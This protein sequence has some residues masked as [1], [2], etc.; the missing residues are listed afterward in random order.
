MSGDTVDQLYNGLHADGAVTGTRENF[1]KFF[2]APGKQGY[3]NRLQLY[4]ALHAD[5]AVSSGTYE[6][7]AQKLGLH[8]RSRSKAV[9]QAVA[10]KTQVPNNFGGL[11]TQTAGMSWLQ[12][13]NMT[14]KQAAASEKRKAASRAAVKGN[15]VGA[16]E[17]VTG[18]KAVAPHVVKHDQNKFFTQT[19]LGDS[20][21]ALDYGDSIEGRI[22]KMEDD[23][24]NAAALLNSQLTKEG[25]D[26]IDKAFAEMAGKDIQDNM[27]MTTDP[28]DAMGN[29]F[30]AM[31]GANQRYGTDAVIKAYEEALPT[32]F[33][34]DKSRKAISEQARKLGMDEEE[35]TQKYML[36]NIEKTIHD[37]LV[38]EG[39]PKSDA[40]YFARGVLS[41]IAGNIFTRGVMTRQGR[42]I[43][44]E[45]TEKYLSDL[46]TRI[47]KD[48]VFSKAGLAKYGNIGMGMASDIAAFAGAGKIAGGM[49]SGLGTGVNLLTKTPLG[50]RLLGWAATSASELT[51]KYG[52]EGAARIAN[53]ASNNKTWLGSLLTDGA[54]GTLRSGL[55]L[56]NYGAMQYATGEGYDKIED[57]KTDNWLGGLL[58]SYSDEFK[59]GLK[60][61]VVGAV[62]STVGRNVGITGA[63]ASNL[64]KITNG[65]KKAAVT[66][67]AFVAESLAFRSEQMA[68]EWAKDHN[69][70]FTDNFIQGAC[71]NMAMKLGGGHYK[72]FSPKNIL[73]SMTMATG[74]R[75]LKLTDTEKKIFLENTDARNLVAA[76]DALEPNHKTQGEGYTA[77]D[78]SGMKYEDR[79]K[80]MEKKKVD[81]SERDAQGNAVGKLQQFLDNKEIPLKLR[82]K[83]SAALGGTMGRSIPRAS[84][85][86]VEQGEKGKYMVKEYSESGELIDAKEH[87]TYDS[88]EGDRQD[89]Y[90]KRQDRDFKDEYLNAMD[91]TTQEDKMN[92]MELVAKDNGFES[93]EDMIHESA[94]RNSQGDDSLDKKIKAD[95][96]RRREEYAGTKAKK[97]LD[98]QR[99]VS[100]EYGVD[101][102]K[103]MDKDFQLRTDQENE[104]IEEFKKRLR[105]E[106][107]DK[108]DEAQNNAVA[109]QDGADLSEQTELEDS[110]RFTENAKT[111]N[112]RQASATDA[113][114]E[115]VK[116]NPDLEEWMK[117]NPN[118]SVEEL[119]ENFGD[120]VADAYMELSNAQAMRDG[121]MQNTGSKIED[122]VRNQVEQAKFTGTMRDKQGGK[123]ITDDVVTIFADKD[124]NEYTLVG[125]DVIAD[126]AGDGSYSAGES[127]LVI[128][129]DKDGNLVQRTN[130]DGLNKVGV[131]PLEDYAN[132]IRT[133]LQEQKTAEMQS[134]ETPLPEAPKEEAPKRE[135][136]ATVAA[137]EK[138]EPNEAN[139]TVLDNPEFYKVANSLQNK[140]GQSLSMDE[141]NSLVSEMEGRAEP[142]RELELTPENWTA[143]FG[144]DGKVNTPVGKV[145]MGENQ[146]AKLFMKG[147]DAEFGMIKPT[148]TSPDVIIEEESKAADGNEE[149]KSSYL[150]V[151]TFIRDGEKVKFFTS[152][153]VKK[154]GMEVSVSSHI[155]SKNAIDKKMQEGKILYIKGV[156]TSNSSDR[157]LA[158]HPNG[159]PDLLPTQEDDT[160]STGKDTTKSSDLQAGNETL[161]F[162]DGTEAP[163]NYDLND[164]P[165][166]DNGEPIYE[167]VSKERTVQDLFGKLDDG[168]LAREY[169]EMRISEA[170]KE[171]KEAKKKE[172][173]MG[174]KINEYLSKK[175]EYE[176]RVK[177]AEDKVA[178]WESVKEDI[179]KLTHTTPEE[180]KEAKEELDG[181]AAREE[182]KK[183]FDE[184]Q[185]ADGVA[186]AAKFVADAKV[187]PESFKKETGMGAA[188]QKS[189]VGMIAKE[190]KGGKSIERLGEDL[191]QLD[192]DEYGGVYFHGDSNDARSAIISALTGAKT[193]KGLREMAEP[194]MERTVSERAQMRDE[195]YNERYGMD[196]EEYLLYS[197][198]EMPHI[199]GNLN[200]FDEQKY[201]QDKAV[202]I[203][204]Q[205]DKEYGKVT[206]ENDSRGEESVHVEG[207]KVLSEERPNDG[208]G[209]E[210]PEKHGG[211]EK[212][213]R[214]SN[215]P[216]APLHE[217]A[218][219]GEGVKK[220]YRKGEKLSDPSD[221]A[222]GIRGAAE[223]FHQERVEKA[224]KAYEEA[225]ASGDTSETKRTKDEY[226]K[227]LDDQLKAQGIGL[228]ERRKTIA[229]EMGEGTKTEEPKE[230]GPKEGKKHWD[231]LSPTEKVEKADADPLTEEEIRSDEENKELA[232]AAIAYLNGD[233][234]LLN[235]IAYLKIYGNV[236]S[237][238]EDVPGNSGT[239]DKA[240]LA[241]S[242]NGSGEG[243]ELEPGRSGGGS[244]EPLDSGTG[245]EAA[246]GK[247]KSGTDSEG[248]LDTAAGEGGDIKGEGNTPGL[249]GV[250]A[251][252]GGR[253]RGGA[254]GGNGNLGSGRGRGSSNGPSKPDGKRKPAA[255]QG[256]TFPN[257]KGTDVK[258][259]TSDAKAAMKAA[260]AEF[261]KRGKKGSASIS[262]VGM[263]NEQIEYL[264]ELMKATGRYGI[265]VMREG[266]YK[267]KEWFDNIREAISDDMKDIGFKDA[268]IDEYI[269]EMWH[270]PWEMDGETHKIGEWASIKG[271]A[272]LRESLKEPLRKKFDK[273]VL[274]EAT[275]VKVGDRKNIEE[276][277]PFLLPQ[278]QD[279]VLKAETQF[280]DES[281]KDK[282]HAGGKGYM[283]TNG[284]GTGKTYTGLGI[285]KRMTKQ[286]KGRILIVTPS[287][288][289]VKDWIN[290]GKNLCLDIRDLDD[291]SKEHGS[292]ATNEKGEGVV[293]TTFANF[294]TNK[295][296][297]EDQFDAVI[298]DESHRIMENKDANETARSRQHYMLTNRNERYALMRLEEINPD[299]MKMRGLAE[300]FEDARKKETARIKEEYEK[301]N[302]SADAADVRI[303]MV[304][305]T[306]KDIQSFSMA[307][308]AK[309]PELGKIYEDYRNAR[310]YYINNV[311]PELEK[312]AKESVDKTKVVFLSA[313]PFNTRE[314]IEYAEGYL[315]SYPERN[316]SG[317]S[318]KAQFFL[319]HFGA[320]YKFRYNRLESST[321]NAE[322][323]AKQEVAFSDW[324]Q[325]DLGTMSGRI[326]DSPYDYSRDFPTVS[327]EHAREFNEACEEISRDDVFGAAYREVLGDY[328]YGSALFET[329]KVAAMLPRLREHIAAGR[330]VVVFHRRVSSKEPLQAPFGMI[331]GENAEKAIKKLPKDKQPEARVRLN[332][333][334]SKY[335]ELLKWEQ[336]L[337]F[338][339]PREQLAKAFGEDN[340]LYFSGQESSKVKNEA[341]KQFND[342]NSGK[343]IIV[344]QEASGK[345]G[346][347][348]HDTTG[349]HQRV[350]I[351]LALPQSPITALQIEG[352]TYRIGNESNAIFEYPVL[353]LV[354]EYNLFAS[355][356]NQQVSTT[357]NLAL[358]SQA[359]NLRE[360]FARGI[361]EHSG[362]VPLDQQGVGGK[363][364]DKAD[365]SGSDPY[366]N[367]V[368][369]YYTNQKLNRNNREGV[370][371]F[372]TP[373]PLGY[374]VVEWANIGEGDSVLEPSAGHGAIARYVPQTNEL[375]AIEPSMSLFA[376]LQMKAG[377]LGR[378]FQNGTFENYYI[379]NKHDA[380]VMNPPFGKAGATAIAHLEKAFGHLEEGGRMVAIIPRGAMDAK[381]VKWAESNKSV[382]PRAYISLPDVTF[383]QAG[384]KVNCR[385]VVI[386]KITDAKL[387]EKADITHV[388]LNRHYDKIEDFF[389]DLRGVEVP[390]RII[391]QQA[392]QMKKSKAAVSELRNMRG[393][394]DVSLDRDG[395]EVGARG[396]RARIEF[397]ENESADAF[398]KRMAGLYDQFAQ[399]EK[400]CANYNMDASAVY[401][402]LK[403]LTC[404]LADMTEDEM[405]RYLT[406]KNSNSYDE[407]GVRFRKG[408]GTG[409]YAKESRIVPQDV[410]KEVSSQIERKF[411][412]DIEKAF[413]DEKERG[414]AESVIYD[415]VEHYSYMKTSEIIDNVNE[416]KENYG[417]ERR[418]GGESSSR[419]H[420]TAVR[421][422]AAMLAS[423]REMEYRRIRTNRIKSLFGIEGSERQIPI[424]GISK[425]FEETK[426]RDSRGRE[427]LFRASLDIA[428]R[429]GTKFYLEE[430]GPKAFHIGVTD[431]NREI[432]FFLD[433]LTRTATKAEEFNVAIVHELLHQSVNGAINLVKKGKAEGFL[434]EKQ[435]DGA[436]TILDIYNKVKGDKERFKE[437]TYGLKS[438]YEFAAQMADQRQRQALDTDIFERVVSA[439]RELVK[440]GDYSLWQR[441]KD[442][443]GKLIGTSDLKKMDKALDNI[444][445]DFKEVVHDYS[446]E[447]IE[448]E[449]FG[450][451]VEDPKEIERLEKEP[452]VKVY[453][454]MQVIDGKLYPPMAAKVRGGLVEPRELGEWERADENPDLAIPDIDKKTGK[455]KVDK[456][457][458]ELKWK[459]KLDK[460]G[461]DAKGKKLGDV[462]AAYN[463]YWHTS[464]SPLNDQFSSA[465]KRPNLRVVEVE[466]PESEL[467]SGYKAERAKDAVGEM[468][469]HSG[470]VSSKLPKEKE[471]KVILSRWDKPVRVLSDAEAADKIAEMLKGEDIEIPDNTITPGLKAELIK[472]GL[473][474]TETDEVKAWNESLRF[475]NE[476]EMTPEERREESRLEEHRSTV[477]KA[478]EKLNTDVTICES[479]DDVTNAEARAAIERGERVKAWYDTRTGEVHLYLPNVT[480]KY[481][482]QKSIAHEVIGHKGMRGL[483]GEDGYR[484]ML[485]RMYTHLSDAEAREVNERMMR[486]GWDFYTAMDEWVADK[487]EESVWQ[488]QE[489]PKYIG[490]SNL[491][492]HIKKSV[493]EAM[494]KAG[495]YINPNVDDVKY[496]LW[497]SKR[498]LRD[499]NAETEMRR[500]A[501]LWKLGHGKMNDDVVMGEYTGEGE[502]GDKASKPLYRNTLDFNKND[503]PT[504][505]ATKETIERE[506][507]SRSFRRTEAWTDDKNGYR[508]FQSEM[509]KGVDDFNS[510]MD[511]YHGAINQ[512]STVAEKQKNF[513]RRELREMEEAIKKPVK[514]LG[515]GQKGYEALNLYL[516][517]K[518]GLE[519]NRVFLARDVADK[520]DGK[521]RK[522]N[523]ELLAKD[524]TSGTITY[525][526]VEHFRDEFH[527][528][529]D[530]LTTL[531]EQGQIDLHQYYNELDRFIKTFEF[532]MTGD[533]V[534]DAK[535]AELNKWYK[536]NIG[537]K[538]DPN[539]NDYSG[540]SSIV[541][542]RQNGAFSDGA[543]I[544]AV[545]QTENTMGGADEVDNL[546]SAIK[547]VT[548]YGLE[549]DFENG[550]ISKAAAERA[551]KMFN[552]YVPMRGFDQETMEDSYS[553]MR[554]D[555]RI[556]SK[557]L[558]TA[559]GRTTLATSPL[560]TAAAMASKAIARGEDNA[561]KQRAYRLVNAWL[562][563]HT[564]TD[565]N[566]QQK[567][568]EVAPAMIS[569]VWFEKKYNSLGSEYWEVASPKITEKMTSEEIRQEIEDFE[570]DMKAKEAQ[571]GATKTL[572]KGVFA[573]PFEAG[574]HKAQNVVN[575]WIGGKMKQIIFTGN[576]R[577]A[578]ALNGELKSDVRQGKLMRMMAG[579]FTSY[580][581]TF[582]IS[583]LS[584]DTLFANNNI[585]NKESAAYYKKFIA[586]QTR[587]LGGMGLGMATMNSN[588][589]IRGEYFNIWAKYKK[590]I[591]PKSKL[592]KLFY[593][594]MDNGG[595]T[596]FVT[597]KTI[598]NFETEIR[599]AAT[600]GNVWDFAGKCFK[601]IPEVIEGLNERSEN[602]NRF[603]CYATSRMMGRSIMRSVTD[604]KE[605]ST[606]F[607]RRGLGSK[608]YDVPEASSLGKFTGVAADWCKRCYLFFN[609]GMQSLRLLST[610]LKNHPIRTSAYTIGIPMVFGGLLIP[611]LNQWLA[612]DDGETYANLPDWDRRNNI[613]LYMG[614]GKWFKVP[615]PIELRAFYGLGDVTRSYF[616]KRLRSEKN[617][618]VETIAQLSQILPW[619]FMGD[620]NDITA[621]AWPDVAKPIVQ[622]YKNKD[623]AGK[624]IY[625]DYDY[626]KNDPEYTK[627]YKGEFEPLVNMSK[628]INEM[629]GGTSVSKGSAD[630]LWNNPAV[631]SN[632]IN[633][634]F[635][636][637][638][639]DAMRVYK[640]GERAVTGNGK[641]FS[642]R[643]IPMM[644]ALISTPTEKTL[645]YRSLNKYAA[646]QEE[647][648]KLEHDI[649]K[650]KANLED[651]EISMKYHSVVRKGSPELQKLAII[652]EAEY[653]IKQARKAMNDK[654]TPE[655]EKDKI[656]LLIDKKKMEVVKELEDLE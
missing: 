484:T 229:K 301:N 292:T 552:W 18:Q 26:Q 98:I 108:N 80:T 499:G 136:P 398:K 22:H 477:E 616:D 126:M 145:K 257:S 114:M 431:T 77:E 262:L 545:M 254:A 493:T 428:R 180:L 173:K 191:V 211:R 506:L 374:K 223:Q 241:A 619:D 442:A 187:T 626:M 133:T 163:A 203:I 607:N 546:W 239:G 96:K 569:D 238:H 656:Q 41:G 130:F 363:D 347:S 514:L 58:N 334:R 536:D 293:I 412:E 587:L 452:K 519:R 124:G 34:S 468:A 408:E 319:E 66:T 315:F 534:V 393:V 535:I 464:R 234:S 268:D 103:A 348:L 490:L 132:R 404:K 645:Y 189:F 53:F 228:V 217:T 243:L 330:K 109:R 13:Q 175:K 48:G 614:K 547:P 427:I 386:D 307:D 308:K 283:F 42:E 548:N 143:E 38:N 364:F 193:R 158:E 120:D 142:A 89:R 610:N 282:A 215:T 476:G 557:S 206:G 10:Y 220:E 134:T 33:G 181:T 230:E 225:K 56:G 205:L 137:S 357:E 492:S 102:D 325:N 298:Y 183:T 231:E 156:S 3:Q 648:K 335:S 531:L 267:A 214:R 113:W 642:F 426:G 439:A 266:I 603:A 396:V 590:G 369:D 391:D 498:A 32:I 84:R 628:F 528:E 224:R 129:R 352:R 169:S 570:G 17:A 316:E 639:S 12:R 375:V 322:A 435:I 14:Q 55:T 550:I 1:R 611:M 296:L 60:F 43:M 197:E 287:Q 518:S 640:L 11:D 344:I 317:Q 472:R 100:E 589:H 378:K 29:L 379:G 574:A 343:N 443:L 36:P 563:N 92:V 413:P 460:G 341:V 377:G 318:G 390:E 599:K 582:S 434:S 300:D 85:I 261:K 418:N 285:I 478:A 280:F 397:K 350:C 349:K 537:D 208:G 489:N 249:D 621:A 497:E 355:K 177:A 508:V 190:E 61:G 172:P 362:Y 339:M 159:V 542:H 583:N 501:F 106:N 474:V 188:E 573:K 290:D 278:Q 469:W 273:Q 201:L 578:Q 454:A 549:C 213:E 532:A 488:P 2:L 651:P 622:V 64:Q 309:F 59:T 637:A 297:L 152:V 445:D 618:V 354:S 140:V 654:S 216:D 305:N 437:N 101:L 527:A 276:T 275:E 638:G 320:G 4:N 16:G 544:D 237:R 263:N 617:I 6:E 595:K 421:F 555:S 457:T 643:E 553:Y 112:D 7:F 147:R 444:M 495:Y 62:G 97:V 483:L 453:R 652:E 416:W 82:M 631:W 242:D 482:A 598:N 433:G 417:R 71:E 509:A 195:A 333:L 219:G 485:R 49:M 526:G 69:I 407:G 373:E 458:G 601:A 212:D 46:D 441:V 104:A 91:V 65:L 591:P 336:T 274:A 174:T 494:H 346:I 384:T 253:E 387:R 505:A 560:G 342:D 28:N 510:S 125:G 252:G 51:K 503:T 556:E 23:K 68:E 577:P 382:A 522:L 459:F 473:K 486:N 256:T 606:N 470:P 608:A 314:N 567:L 361:E 436:K 8:A 54:K 358:G 323:L 338:S 523:K 562:K 633:G 74:D 70:N 345:E 381:F 160:P 399:N 200:N 40:E 554:G 432:R 551:K 21:L 295:T 511:A 392:K 415:F 403:D 636:G 118:A 258:K 196:Y 463:P 496:W 422:K 564:E 153:T 52:V 462:P 166:D 303:Y 446:M 284:T 328:N 424:D 602:L 15:V 93:V 170:E 353:G 222:E 525:N 245:G 351:T 127:G 389:E 144:E 185:P 561:N 594:F 380:I 423:E 425:A 466:V 131:F 83:V 146:L 625:K 291:W 609:A 244:A 447:D 151:K 141:A 168:N 272:N 370:D 271:Y 487:A 572:Q 270:M 440:K 520:I 533:N 376:K 121:F 541:Q 359:R 340:V 641:D 210:S 279:D 630:G 332:E 207:D 289:K 5:G 565:A 20:D 596:G 615:L 73:R 400:R 88:A 35:F 588:K 576:P 620:G 365:E 646:Y 167:S 286:G 321:A 312:Q 449:G 19:Q 575:V 105:G 117:S 260:F 516:F 299:C 604:A 107:T 414:R 164:I 302:P 605:V 313:T 44:N 67:G 388:D 580:N 281:H 294:G 559:K 612:D 154:D 360:S 233:K 479:I 90:L 202:D 192:N 31:R 420:Y 584:R 480:D 259:E 226:R 368:L 507:T 410:D 465:Y 194:D 161:T 411:D 600:G 402:E 451:K 306:P 409:K 240:Q 178:Y 165:M 558:A 517:M 502:A 116:N 311:K 111:V 86:A 269:R 288:Q 79:S 324:L 9:Q 128:F 566:G 149:R 81:L 585:A 634:Y 529:K 277:L 115:M 491:W 157:H 624:P 198:Q 650:W 50:K 251:G 76:C 95:Y 450:Y 644:R 162:K 37:R 150:F 72:Q 455:Q 218:P 543:I 430:A 539:S 327:V 401:G 24:R 593:E 524:P 613:C 383:Q 653:L 179:E 647:A 232:A 186:L 304:K 63:E 568:T 475:R 255:K 209:G 448:Q 371:Y 27:N 372:P 405:R 579:M 265:A 655:E 45:G 581:V 78:T 456:K 248:S 326:I 632:I 367:A 504:N 247:R 176:E 356:F 521:I 139:S 184:T 329:M 39:I 122:A 119:R 99:E 481:D 500:N 627:V 538:Y 148:L 515:G 123:V 461:K 75:G 182:F 331:L 366:D 406:S 571:G 199:L 623:W 530:Y 395:L 87:S 385:V 467:T 438:E 337:D 513:E 394:Y 629:S 310:D 57:G 171:L 227:A 471:R 155:K 592:E 586:L 264:P 94:L 47:E 246:P 138:P 597:T 25:F 236:R 135:K 649:K 429:L 235:Q 512:S 110:E 30:G 419:M 204:N 635:G 221:V 540:I 250:P